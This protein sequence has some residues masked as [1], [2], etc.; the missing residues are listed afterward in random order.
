M[1]DQPE[2][3]SSPIASG[4]SE[5]R[6]IPVSKP[7]EGVDASVAVHTDHPRAGKTLET[8]AAQLAN[9]RPPWQPGES[10]NPKGRPATGAVLAELIDTL[11]DLR[12]TEAELRAIA[13]N[14]NEE[15]PRRVAARR[16]LLMLEHGDLADFGDVLSGEKTL[17]QL[18]AEGVST[19]IVKKCK[20][21]TRTMEDGTVEVE[22]EI[23]LHDRSG[24]E[25][26]RVSDRTAGKPSQTRTNINVEVS[27][28]GQLDLEQ[29]LQDAI[30]L[31]E[32]RESWPPQLQAYADRQAK[33]IESK[34]VG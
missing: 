30:L 19:D 33:Q 14:Q 22:R 1:I 9:L 5:S 20:T 27:A 13:N 16:Y 12:P 7:A 15:A 32:P 10:G 25:F 23:E 4:D 17:E 29:M 6:V 26:D 2:Q 31:G 18:R 24:E 21:K 3:S 28:A 34:V 11:T 8:R